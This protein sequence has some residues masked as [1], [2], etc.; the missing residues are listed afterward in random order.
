MA[1]KKGKSNNKKSGGE[2]EIPAVLAHQGVQVQ[3][4]TEEMR[5]SYLDY[6]VTLRCMTRW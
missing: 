4:I 2:G 6:A 3:S 5:A 1:E